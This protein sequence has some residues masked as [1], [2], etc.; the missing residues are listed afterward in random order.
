MEACKDSVMYWCG[1]FVVVCLHGGGVLE[2]GRDREP[3]CNI[4]TISLL[5]GRYRH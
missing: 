2:Y 3:L 1:V 5:R 4:D